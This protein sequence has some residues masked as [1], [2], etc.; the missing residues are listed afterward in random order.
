VTTPKLRLRLLNGANR[1][2]F[3]LHFADNRPFTQIASD[4]GFLDP[5]I[6]LTKLMLTP[7]E[8]AEVVVNFSDCQP[9]ERVVLMSDDTPLVNFDIGNFSPNKQPIA[10]HLVT[11]PQW[12]ADTDGQLQTTVMS[13]MDE[14]VRLDGQLFDMTR[15]DRQQ[16]LGKTVDWDVKNTNNPDGGMIHPF[17]MHGCHFQVISR[18]G[19]APYPN[20]TGF[21]DT[22]GV[23]SGET[24]RIRVRFDVLGDFMYHCHIL[25][26]EDT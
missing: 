17:H 21:K 5:V 12:Q 9:G 13:G 10:D 6:D 2:E 15:I 20:E 19:H 7:A 16:Q 25:E 26:H 22:I 14:N 23:N 18:N 1:R 8:R 24:V 3:R 4:C 11:I